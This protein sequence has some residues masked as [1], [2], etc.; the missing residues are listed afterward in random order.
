MN[1]KLDRTLRLQSIGR[2]IALALGLL[3][4][5]AAT[6]A[7]TFPA[8]LPSFACEIKPLTRSGLKIA[9]ANRERF[10]KLCLA[11]IEDEC[12][13]RI[14][15]AG[16]EERETLCRNTYCLPKKVKRL[17]FGEGYNMNYRY[18][19]R[20]SADGVTTVLD[21]E[22]LEGEPKGVTGKKTK[23]EHRAMLNKL[24]SRVEYE[25]LI[26]EGRAKALINLETSWKIGA[27]Y[28]K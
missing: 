11:C 16:Y 22:Y 24:V 27:D 4:A 3:T 15:P 13:M 5:Q 14:W 21:G 28:N 9:Q 23:I 25:P 1:I 20:V 12:A 8:D 19:Y 18:R 26:L 17:A 2:W 6:A 10:A 7:Q